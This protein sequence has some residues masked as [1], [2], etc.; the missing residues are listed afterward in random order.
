MKRNNMILT[1]CILLTLMV[2]CVGC[3]NKNAVAT[4]RQSMPKDVGNASVNT[5]EQVAEINKTNEEVDSKSKD[6]VSGKEDIVYEII[7]TGKEII[8]LPTMEIDKGD[9]TAS[10]TKVNDHIVE[11]DLKPSEGIEFESNGDGTCTIKGIGVCTDKDIVI[12]TESPNG[13]TVTLIDEYAFYNMD[14]VDSVSLVNGMYVVDDYAFQYGEFSTLNIVGGSPIINKSAFSSCEDLKSVSIRD[15]NLQAGEYAFFSCGKGADIVFSNCTGTIEQYAFQY[16]DFVSLTIDK[17]DLEIEKS[18]FSTCED[19]VSIKVT[20]SVVEAGEYSFFG[21]GDSA[22]VE[23]TGC[24]LTADDYAFQYSS[25]DS[26]LFRGSRFEVGK[27]A[28][29]SCDDLNSVIIDCDL[30]DLD[31]YAFF[32]CEDLA[33]VSLCENTKE[34]NEIVIDD[35]AFQYCKRLETVSIG[36]GNIEIG[37]YVFTGCSDGLIISNAGNTYTAESI[38]DGLLQ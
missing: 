7:K 27:S 12:P 30:I 17:C 22:V 21:C 19:L 36:A 18:A 8:P 35:Y 28:F 38:K 33:S 34:T 32:C 2:N 3:G 31:E 16:S 37:R 26:L 23:M 20:D 14:D 13:D 11:T 24:S 6:L 9:D 10:E 25:L 29:S 5:E 15:C 1:G 4:N